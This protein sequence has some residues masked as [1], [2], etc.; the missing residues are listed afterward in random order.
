MECLTWRR[1]IGLC[2]PAIDPNVTDNDSPLVGTEKKFPELE[3]RVTQVRKRGS[4]ENCGRPR[5]SCKIR[6]WNCDEARNDGRR[7]WPP[8]R[9]VRYKTGA[10]HLR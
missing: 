3:A 7:D 5:A 9:Y 4:L 8:H 2:L 6:M 1:T 10:R